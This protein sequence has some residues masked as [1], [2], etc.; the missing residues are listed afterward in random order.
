[1]GILF[2]IISRLYGAKRVAILEKN[3]ARVKLLI[4]LKFNNLIIYNS[5]KKLESDINK[6]KLK[7]F[8]RIV[9]ATSSAELHKRSINFANKNSQINLYGGLPKKRINFDVNKI[10]YDQIKITGSFSSN[11]KHLA[12]AL[13]FIEK[14]QKLLKKIVSNSANFKN[15]PKKINQLKKQKFVKLIFKP[16]F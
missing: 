11:Q 4:N 9:S 10:H 14:N 15:L 5:L 13:S 2:A 6:N 12:L 8:D 1:M 7:K 16:T 3:Y